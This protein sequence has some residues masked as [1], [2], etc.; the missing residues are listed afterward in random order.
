MNG[1]LAG[2]GV[3]VCR[4][5]VLGQHNQLFKLFD[6]VNDRGESKDLSTEQPKIAAQLLAEL[7]A[8]TAAVNAPVPS[9]INPVFNPNN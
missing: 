1:Q 9:R 3:H 7:K 8:W 4:T 5:N 2:K 6:V